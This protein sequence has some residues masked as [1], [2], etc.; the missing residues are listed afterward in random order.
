MANQCSAIFVGF[1]KRVLVICRKIIATDFHEE[2]KALLHLEI[3]LIWSALN[4]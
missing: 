3:F 2:R 4:I 1:V